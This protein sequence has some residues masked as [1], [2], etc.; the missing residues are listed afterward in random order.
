[1]RAT[2]ILT[3]QEYGK[4]IVCGPLE[5]VSFLALFQGCQTMLSELNGFDEL[6]WRKQRGSDMPASVIMAT[7][8]FLS[9]FP[10][11]PAKQRVSDLRALT[12]SSD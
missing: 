10:P 11:I 4:T 3:C 9:A 6:G 7:S 1:M 5:L 12:P 8:F 2:N